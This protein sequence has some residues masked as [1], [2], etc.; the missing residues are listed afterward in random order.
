MKEDEKLRKYENILFAM[1]F[2]RVIQHG[3]GVLEAMHQ[4]S[5]YGES[6]Y[7]KKDGDS[8]S[9]MSTKGPLAKPGN[10][11]DVYLSPL[12]EDL[13]MLWDKG[14]D[15]FDS[16][17][18]MPPNAVSTYYEGLSLG[19]S[20]WLL[21]L[22]KGIPSSSEIGAMSLNSYQI[23]KANYSIVNPSSINQDLSGSITPITVRI[24]LQCSYGN[25]Q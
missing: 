25:R 8:S 7:K 19:S 23:T 22:R 4:C 13:R 18:D 3:H 11:I 15:A 14:V 9:D 20:L 6:Q 12:I 2:A 5:K 17:N 16:V 1:G 10:D 24:S 21:L